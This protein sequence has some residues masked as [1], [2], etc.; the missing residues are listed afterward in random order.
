MKLRSWTSVI[1]AGLLLVWAIPAIAA[2]TGDDATRVLRVPDAR[3][4]ILEVTVLD[5][6]GNPVSGVKVTAVSKELLETTAITNGK[7]V[8]VL[9]G[10]RTDSKGTVHASKNLRAVNWDIKIEHGRINY[11]TVRYNTLCYGIYPRKYRNPLIVKLPTEQPR[12][13]RRWAPVSYDVGNSFPVKG[14]KFLDDNWQQLTY[15]PTS[16]KGQI[17]QAYFRPWGIHEGEAD[18]PM[19][20]WW[21]ISVYTYVNCDK[22]KMSG[23]PDKKM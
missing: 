22:E 21:H 9:D 14:S 23:A 5:P 2:V 11:L 7:G 20:R 16:N 1:L 6:K 19:V 8:A 15:H 17:T 12:F 3:G 4:A 18:K 13:E 10:L